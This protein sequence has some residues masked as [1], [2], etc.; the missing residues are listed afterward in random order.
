MAGYKCPVFGLKYNG[1]EYKCVILYAEEPL[2]SIKRIRDFERSKL[3]HVDQ[4][5]DSGG[6]RGGKG[7][8]MPPQNYF[9]PPHFAPPQKNVLVTE[10]D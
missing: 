10:S 5:K 2:E 1:N 8:H 7:G 9:L 3:V 4:V 6:A